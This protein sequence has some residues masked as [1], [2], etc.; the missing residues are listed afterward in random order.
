MGKEVVILDT[1][2]KEGFLEMTL[3]GRPAGWRGNP[4][5][6]RSVPGKTG[7]RGEWAWVSPGGWCVW[8]RGRGES[9]GAEVR[10]KGMVPDGLGPRS[11]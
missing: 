4:L 6:E 1:V 2:V 9:S 5:R 8:S 7:S 3:G 11:L 10:G